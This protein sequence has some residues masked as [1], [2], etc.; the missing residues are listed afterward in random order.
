MPTLNATHDPRLKSF[1]TAANAPDCDFPIQNLPFGCFTTGQASIGRIGVAIG[2]QILDITV[3][4]AKGLFSGMAA[5][6][7]ALCLGPSLNTLMAA[8]PAHWSALRA[9]MAQLLAQGGRAEARV[10]ESLV[11]MR[12]AGMC[13]PVAIGDYSD[14]L[15]SY[16]HAINVGRL[17]RPDNPLA[18]NFYY[19]PIGYHGRGSSIVVSG[20]P[21][22]RPNGQAK[23]PDAPAPTFGP[24]RRLDYELELG[25]FV[26]P[27]NPMG[28]PIP[29]DQ[30]EDQVFGMCI[31]NDWSA[32]DIQA[33]ESTPLG[34]FLGK[35]F[36]STISPWGAG[37]AP[38]PLFGP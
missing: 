23:A 30:A 4:R 37:A 13:L 5:E 24:S 15:C 18:P 28:R 34:P 9:Q 3:A 10:R 29:L 27:G 2:D 8:G 31:L 17:F 32:R 35:S 33:W 21:C 19:I 38:L 36:T 14:F 25:F 16:H 7:A 6:A 11:P 1:V 20:T 12:A 22:V 26:G